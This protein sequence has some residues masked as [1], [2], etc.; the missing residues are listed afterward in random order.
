MR[1]IEKKRRD[2]A[3]GVTVEIVEGSRKVGVGAV[4]AEGD[5]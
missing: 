1:S 3:D 2:I 5:N 4:I